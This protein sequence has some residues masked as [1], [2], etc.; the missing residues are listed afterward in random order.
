M[1]KKRRRKIK[2]IASQ[3]NEPVITGVAWYNEEQYPLL[4]EHATDADQ[5]NDTFDKWKVNAQN[6]MQQLMA[7]GQLVRPVPVDM[8]EMIAWC[9]AENRPFDGAARAAY[10]SAR[11]RAMT[12]SETG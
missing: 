6:A 7:M 9:K 8:H 5:L 1:T 3:A 2:R 12:N 4:L 10:V 11:L